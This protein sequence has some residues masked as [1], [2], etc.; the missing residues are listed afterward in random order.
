MLS[1]QQRYRLL[2]N[3]RKYYPLTH[4]FDHDVT[5]L[6]DESCNPEDEL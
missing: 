2:R 4:K 1:R 3:R 5:D 6:V